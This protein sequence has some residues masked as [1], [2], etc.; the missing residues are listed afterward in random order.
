MAGSFGEDFF[1][2]EKKNQIC[3]EFEKQSYA[4]KDMSSWVHVREQRYY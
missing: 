3:P 1:L 2:S 4:L